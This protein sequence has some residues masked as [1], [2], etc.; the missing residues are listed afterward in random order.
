MSKSKVLIGV[1]GTGAKVLEAFTYLTIAG[2][3]GTVFPSDMPYNL[4]MVDTDKENG[5]LARLLK[6][7]T[8]LNDKD[9]NKD[10]GSPM[11]M[12][13]DGYSKYSE[14]TPNWVAGHISHKLLPADNDTN[15]SSSDF[16]W[17]IE[18][19]DIETLEQLE[20]ALKS[21]HGLR[22][23]SPLLNAL[24]GDEDMTALQNV[25]FHGRPRIGAL[26]L[27]YEFE[28]DS[29]PGGSGFWDALSNQNIFL[30]NETQLMFTGS[31]FG[32]TGASGIPNLIRLC[33]KRYFTEDSKSSLGMTL[34]LPYY[35]FENSDEE[36]PAD[37]RQF[38]L[39]SKLA[40]LYY[41]NSKLL[42][43]LSNPS[44][45]LIG[46]DVSGNMKAISGDVSLAAGKEK[47]IN[48]ALPAELT[49]AIS[50][51][52][53]FRNKKSEA[54]VHWCETG[55]ITD[56]PTESLN[57]RN[58]FPIGSSL[59]N[60]LFRLASFSLLWKILSSNRPDGVSDLLAFRS[61]HDIKSEKSKR[62][63]SVLGSVD[64]FATDTLNWLLQLNAN[65]ANLDWFHNSHMAL[66]DFLYDV[67]AKKKTFAQC[68]IYIGSFKVSDWFMKIDKATRRF[69]ELE[70]ANREY[71]KL[72]YA[73]MYVCAEAYAL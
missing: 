23:I 41:H 14:N 30:E 28:K 47:Q 12:H 68:N 38:R 67:K 13:F 42:S 55:N 53:Y 48:P 31:I 35:K 27:Q 6:L 11:Q 2:F 40:L 37:P 72:L 46:R 22:R 60:A 61:L 56:M 36:C 7:L 5:N 29:S 18:L 69:K 4:R 71:I 43:G 21:E 39:N 58:D 70:T 73:V 17:Q 8:L 24:Y 66:E 51:I 33:Q 20:K 64:I 65:N 16:L 25:G 52:D 15:K 59:E 44:V 9:E 1:G 57:I 50:L 32:G 49:A 10:Y 34:L 62:W 45:Y 26:R 54:E 3:P 63:V 19:T